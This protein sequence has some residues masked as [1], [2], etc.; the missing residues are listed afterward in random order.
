MSFNSLVCGNVA[1]LVS[2]IDKICE[3][4]EM[5][6]YIS[7]SSILTTHGHSL[8][9]SVMGLIEISYLF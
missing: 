7:V 1:E 4:I 5:N 3:R 2:G 9:G 6:S 8:R